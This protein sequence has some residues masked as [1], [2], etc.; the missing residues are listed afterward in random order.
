MYEHAYIST[1]LYR[2][3][4]APRDDDRLWAGH[5]VSDEQQHF[6]M[7]VYDC[8]SNDLYQ[9]T[10]VICICLQKPTKFLH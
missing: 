6:I 1:N 7:Q 9:I 4:R 5:V 8:K 2:T 3:F 10:L